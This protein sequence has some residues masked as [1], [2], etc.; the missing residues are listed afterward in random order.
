MLAQK[1]FKNSL[2][3]AGG[4]V[5]PIGI[6][7]IF[8]PYIVHNLGKEE[9]GILSIVSVVTGYFAFLDLGLGSAGIK[10]I[11]EYYPKK[12]FKTV[13]SIIN[14]LTIVYG[15]IGIIGLIGISLLTDLLA[16]KVFKIPPNLV[17]VTKFALHVAAF[18]FFITFIK[19]IFAGIPKAIHRFDIENVVHIVFGTLGTLLVVLLL[20]FGYALKEIVILK[21]FLGLGTLLTY[22]F[23][24]KRLFPFYRLEISLDKELMKRLFSFGGFHI[25]TSFI[26]LVSQHANKLVI[27]IMLGPLWLTY[28]VIPQN[29]TSRI[30]GLAYKLS[31]IIFPL[32]SELSSTNQHNRMINIYLKMSRITLTFKLAVFVPLI[33]FSHKILFF[34]MGKDFADQGW[35]VMTILSIGFF[36][37]SLSQIPGMINMGYG[38]P[39]LNTIFS[40]IGVVLYLVQIVPYTKHWGLIGAAFAWAIGTLLNFVFISVTNKKT[41]GLSNLVFFN[42]VFLKPLL[43]T[44]IQIGVIVF[45]LHNYINSLAMLIAF[46]VLSIVFYFIIAFLM[47]VYEKQEKEQFLYFIKPVLNRI[48]FRRG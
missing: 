6:S 17:E 3:N 43:V 36:L 2:F 30:N 45:I 1:S 39:K 7:L 16:T 12:D 27:G 19:S 9:Y 4:F 28:F 15:V 31:E 20:Y 18:G 22:I 37:T 10:Y 5:W 42:K 24:A 41:L 13:N 32:A 34:W 23:I 46:F 25:F 35:I 38:N 14:I 48:S 11:S 8:T 29:L 26:N 44:I 47:G 21:F 33:F 40:L